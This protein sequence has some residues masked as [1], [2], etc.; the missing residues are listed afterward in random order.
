MADSINE[1]YAL[2]AVAISESNSIHL[3][4]VELHCCFS[5]RQIYRLDQRLLSFLDSVVG[6]LQCSYLLNLATPDLN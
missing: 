3:L 5:S 4:L 6:D 1:H 2:F